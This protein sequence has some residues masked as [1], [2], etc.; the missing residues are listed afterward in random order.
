MVDHLHFPE[1]TYPL[2]V[3]LCTKCWL[4]QLPT[5]AEAHELFTPEY[6]YFSS[7]SISWCDHARAYVSNA[8]ERLSL[9]KNSFV[10]EIGS[11]DGYLLQYV[12]AKGIKCLGIEPTTA[13]ATASRSKGIETIENF[14]CSQLANELASMGRQADLVVAN[15]VLAHVPDINDFMLGVT[16]LL[17]PN[18]LVSFE[19]PHLLELIKGNQFDTIYHEH[20]SYLSLQ[21]VERIALIAGLVIVDVQELPTHGGTLRLWLSH[22]DDFDHWCGPVQQ[23]AI[24]FVRSK[25]IDAQLESAIP[26]IGFQKRAL[27]AKLSLLEFLVQASQHGRRVLGYGAAAKG[28][29][30]LNY[31]GIKS[32]LL[33]FVADLAPSKQ[34]RYMPGSH[35]P[36]ISVDE[37]LDRDPH[38]ILLLP[39]N[40]SK[41]IKQQLA[42]K[43]K[44]RFYKAIPDLC[45]I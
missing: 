32:D 27:Q 17:K 7:T 44:A 6:A 43:T 23:R 38:D 4:M 13:T 42:H 45:C 35:I 10:V 20:Y 2:K 40:L 25:E 29:T 12:Q 26:Y 16:T 31:S 37:F 1:V 21:I 5:H 36:I 8:I 14:F 3:Y 34:G 41:E 9:N 30:L 11:N 24:D 39:W 33:E 19:F 22:K 28:N 18:G 15:N